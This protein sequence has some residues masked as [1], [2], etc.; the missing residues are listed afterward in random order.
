MFGTWFIKRR[1]FAIKRV[2]YM[3][4]VWRVF[5]SSIWSIACVCF[6]QFKNYTCDQT[7]L[8]DIYGPLWTY[9]HSF[10]YIYNKITK[11]G[12]VPLLR[13]KSLEGRRWGWTGLPDA[14]CILGRGCLRHR[15]QVGAHLSW[16]HQ[17]LFWAGGGTG[18]VTDH[19]PAPMHA[20]EPDLDPQ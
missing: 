7:L 9:R 3:K 18:P 4:F 11:E 5:A 12:V 10:I 20:E 13:L 17:L 14:A 19:S 15:P 2:C 6:L 8:N 16:H 1:L